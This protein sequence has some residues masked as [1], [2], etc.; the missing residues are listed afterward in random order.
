[1][2][3]PQEIP[4]AIDDRL[5]RGKRRRDEDKGKREECLAMWYGDQFKFYDPAKRVVSAQPTTT[6]SFDTSSKPPWR[7]RRTR[8]LIFD[9]VEREVSA[10]TSKIPGYEINPSTT[11]PQDVDAAKLSQK[12]ATYGY[13]RWKMGMASKAVVRHAVIADDGFAWPYFD[14]SVGP[15]ITGTNM[16]QGEICVRT[17]S[18]SEVMWEA[19]VPFND[20]PWLAI[21]QAQEMGKVMGQDGFIKGTK[22][23]A[24]AETGDGGSAL[25]MVTEYLERPSPQYP[26]GRWVTMANKKIIV[27]G[28]DAEG[29]PS[30]YR[31]YPCADPNGE[32]IDEPVLHRLTYAQ[33]PGEDRGV[34][35]VRHLVDLQRIV[36]DMPNRQ[37]EWVRLALNPQIIV[38][39]GGF[40]KGTRITD[41]PGAVYQAFGSGDVIFRP[42]PP[43]PAELE[44]IKQSA[45]ADM[46]RIAAQNDIPQNVEAGRA[47]Q[48]LI[49]RDSTRRASFIAELA[50]FHSRLMRHCLYLV[51]RHYTE[52]RIVRIRGDFGTENIANFKGAQ[53]RG[54]ADVTVLP[55][56]I[57]NRTRESITQI[58]LAF[59]DR[60]WIDPQD[61]MAAIDNGTAAGLVESFERDQARADLL[62]QRIR[63]GSIVNM[64]ERPPFPGE[65]AV[66][67][68]GM[69]LMS[70]PGWMPR[71]IDNI[72][73]QKA[74]FADWMKTSDYDSLDPE[75]QQ[76]ANTIY[77][78]YLQVE[79]EQAAQ[80]QAAEMAQAEDLGMGNA[81]KP[82][83]K[84]M[85]SQPGGDGGPGGG[86]QGGAA[87]QI[88]GARYKAGSTSTF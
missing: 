87:A 54:Q 41:E 36:N 4:K 48:S 80:A 50:E 17:F 52:E 26:E 1:M 2:A 43:I 19:G 45:I 28:E 39:N 73:V 25:I 29:K 8:N 7:Q 53:L 20:S 11:D 62:I 64:P 76:V 83:D 88:F 10:V 74:R 16:G 71:P 51:Q 31:P 14:N 22:L 5:S 15:Y 35:L 70:V 68:T 59:A 58:V 32:P 84:G 55:G 78:G 61:A 6:S 75:M 40:A 33:P 82:Q 81:A 49:E 60:G 3:D 44:E 13:D 57:E 77:A 79:A 12:V 34:G 63:D 23:V 46:G 56:S 18:A 69:P 38:Q 72:P 30:I 66:D 42:V 37:L 65:N 86:A 21:E 67:E 47:I 24:D 27:M 85:P 9:I